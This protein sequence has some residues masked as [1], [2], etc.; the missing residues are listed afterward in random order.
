[1]KARLAWRTLFSLLLVGAFVT[2]CANKSHQHS[3]YEAW[4]WE[5]EQKVDN[6]S[7]GESQ[8]VVVEEKTMTR[9]SRRSDVPAGYTGAW[10]AVP[11]GE[12]STSAVL[13]EKMVPERVVAGS[14]YESYIIVTN[15]TDSLVLKDLVLTDTFY[16]GYTL[17]SSSPAAASS[18]AGGAT[19]RMEQLGPGESQ[20]I[21]LNGSSDEVGEIEL[22][23]TID[24]TPVLCISTLAEQPALRLTKTGTANALLCDPITYTLTV[25]NTGTGTARNVVVTDNLPAG[26]TTTDGQS[27]VSYEVAALGA[28][29]SQEFTI[30]AEASRTGTFTNDASAKADDGLSASSGDVTTVICQPVLEVSV[31]GTDRTYAGR[32]ITFNGTVTN[33]GD[34]AS[35]DTVV[36][37]T[38]PDCTTFDSANAGGTQAG[39]IVTWSVGRLEPGATR[40]I[41]LTVQADEICVARTTIEAE[42][43]CAVPDEASAE[44]ELL[45]IPAVLL[46]VIDEVDPVRVGDTTIYVITVT[47]QGSALDTNI[48]ITATL[49]GMD[50]VSN[51]GATAGSIAGRTITFAPLASLDPKAEAEWRIT[52]RAAEVMDARF[53]VTMTT[54]N[55]GDRPVEETEATNLYD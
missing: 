5:L 13:V 54:D 34:C 4:L 22:C 18:N 16:N 8:K 33:T 44:T 21:T 40:N 10:M 12:E 25:T 42:G 9:G 17:S 45:G 30:N 32:K 28:G 6:L 41:V 31:T 20:K 14:D 36:T 49:E 43:E 37:M 2:G 39:G 38:V 26:V 48:R 35:D 24:Y 27:S 55:T 3:D 7:T 52:A 51:S 46:E 53:K 47:N 50:H 15:V 19:W 11:T 23:S 1:M 29:E